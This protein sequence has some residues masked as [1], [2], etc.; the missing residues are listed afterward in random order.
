MKPIAFEELLDLA[1]YERVRDTFL[2]RVI[3]RKRPRY[4]K[5]GGNMTVLFENRDTVMLQVQEMLRTER[6]TQKSAILHELETYNELVPGDREL[7]ATV[8]VEYEDRAERERMLMALASL[9]DK[10]RLRIDGEVLPAPPDRRGTDP[11][12]TMAVHYIKFPLSDAAQ[13]ALRSGQAQVTLEVDHPAYRAVATI[14]PET[15][16]S[17]RDDFEA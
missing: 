6:I 12:R 16:Q 17:L 13:R 9:E 14:G 3:E 15:M 10:F 4:V 5:L 1:A 7:S 11:A 2:R 8:F